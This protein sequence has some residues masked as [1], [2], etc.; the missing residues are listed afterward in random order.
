[1]SR[2]KQKYLNKRQRTGHLGKSE[3]NTSTFFWKSIKQWKIIDLENG[4]KQI[5]KINNNRN[6]YTV[7]VVY[8]SWE[9]EDSGNSK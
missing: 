2:S 7:Y 8:F 6:Q 1:M 3:I 9:T 5:A 4:V